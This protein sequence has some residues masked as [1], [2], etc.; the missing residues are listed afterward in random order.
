MFDVSKP[1]R[2][3]VQ[4][5]LASQG[6]R[7]SR[8]QK[9]SYADLDSRLCGLYAHFSA[10]REMKMRTHSIIWKKCSGICKNLEYMRKMKAD[11]ARK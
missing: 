10:G 9:N 5:G 8:N 11:Q 4:H 3:D 2:R 7:T 6:G 1:L